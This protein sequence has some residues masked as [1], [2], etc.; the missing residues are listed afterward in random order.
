[1][2]PLLASVFRLEAAP[3]LQDM[4]FDRIIK[5][6]PLKRKAGTEKTQPNKRKKN[7]SIGE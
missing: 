7:K 6:S 5:D 3:G 1:M 2:L 4:S